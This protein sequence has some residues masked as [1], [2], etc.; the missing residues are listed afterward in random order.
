MV[1]PASQKGVST[2]G[3]F[4][5]DNQPI[6]G[7]VTPGTVELCWMF[8]LKQ[9][10]PTLDFL[11]S[12]LALHF[13][14]YALTSFLV[15]SI[16]SKRGPALDFLVSFHLDQACLLALHFIYKPL[17]LIILLTWLK[18]TLGMV[19]SAHSSMA[20]DTCSIPIS[21]SSIPFGESFPF[22]ILKMQFCS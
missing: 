12:S 21:T 14:T 18:V 16:A 1:L 4:T 6:T 3:D 22:V 11:L 8:S 2:R 13:L 9:L 10:I 7:H 20:L 17:S 19:L 5:I 15:D